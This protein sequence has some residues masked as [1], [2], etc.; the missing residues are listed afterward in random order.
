MILKRGVNLKKNILKVVLVLASF[1]LIFMLA[2]C[3]A[4]APKTPTPVV[5]SIGDRI[6]ALE[7]QHAN[8]DGNA[9]KL[10]TRVSS[11]EKSIKNIPDINEV[12]D[13]VKKANTAVTSINE[14]QSK[15]NETQSKAADAQLKANDAQTKANDAQNKLVESQAKITALEKEIAT[16]KQAD[17]SA[18]WSQTQTDISA[19][20]SQLTTLQ[21]KV[22]ALNTSTGTTGDDDDTNLIDS[23]ALSIKVTSGKYLYINDIGG[24]AL[25]KPQVTGS[26]ASYP[27]LK[28]KISNDSK[29]DVSVYE[30]KLTLTREDYYGGDSNLAN[31][32]YEISTSSSFGTD[33]FVVDSTSAKK[34]TFYSVVTYD[35]EADDYDEIP[36]WIR[37][38][39]N[40][41]NELYDQSITENSY[42]GR[43]KLTSSISITDY[44]EMED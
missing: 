21:N 37:V 6:T 32:E 42:P 39:F 8:T 16:L 10:E 27:Y 9:A 25:Y 2:G 4:S 35:I 11:V 19:L 28:F 13:A 34:V 1:I 14:A 12:N 33:A 7:T 24:Q 41:D 38:K 3:T 15:I 5:A 31:Y 23:G 18:T 40:Q 26:G 36:I 22:D 43:L 29:N 20:K 30:I 17:S 44:E